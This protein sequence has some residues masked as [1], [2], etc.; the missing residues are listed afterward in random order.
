MSVAGSGSYPPTGPLFK[1]GFAA[2]D[3]AGI[4]DLRFA[5][6]PGEQGGGTASTCHET[7]D[8]RVNGRKV[9]GPRWGEG[10]RRGAAR[11]V[12]SKL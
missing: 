1:K 10:R 11:W 9:W 5:Q 3:V 12:G 4:K 6:E 2:R 8:V 7:W